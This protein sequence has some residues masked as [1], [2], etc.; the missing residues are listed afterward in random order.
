[1]NLRLILKDPLSDKFL[2]IFFFSNMQESCVSLHLRI[3]NLQD[4][5]TKN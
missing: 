3:I 1:M 5:Q 4:G 2:I